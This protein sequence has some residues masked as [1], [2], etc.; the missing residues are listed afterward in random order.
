MKKITLILSIIILVSVSC[1]PGKRKSDDQSGK[2][3][4]CNAHPMSGFQQSQRNR[5]HNSHCVD[6]RRE[7]QAESGSDQKSC[8]RKHGGCR[9]F[10]D[11][12]G[13]QTAQNQEKAR[14]HKDADQIVPI[15]RA[16]FRVGGN[17]VKPG[18]GA[19]NS[20]DVAART[21]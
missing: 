9:F 6:C 12:A 3:S 20:E 1:K 14:K 15:G 7:L 19:A 8:G 5:E 11:P 10:Q 13:S 2:Q 18:S 4:D 21:P 17:A 16:E